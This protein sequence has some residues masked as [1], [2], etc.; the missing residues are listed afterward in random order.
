MK[1]MCDSPT[2]KNIPAPDCLTGSPFLDANAHRIMAGEIPN[3]L[4]SISNDDNFHLAY[5]VYPYHHPQLN[6]TCEDTKSKTNCTIY[7]ISTTENIYESS[8]DDGVHAVGATEMKTKLKSREAIWIAAGDKT[9]DFHQLDEVT[10]RCSEINAYTIKWAYDQSSAEA[11]ARYN[12]VGQKLVAGPDL[13]PYNDGPSWIWRAM[14]YVENADK[15]EMSVQSPAMK[16]K[17]DYILGF[18]AGIHY[19]K[20]LSPFRAMEWI[21]FDS[22][23]A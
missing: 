21:Y 7:A 16:F 8:D 3:K 11:K 22:L 6:N 2:L 9:A 23:K 1:K 10:D 14:Q 5:T 20:L 12:K 15:T 19:C 13:G 18:S 4:V 17:A